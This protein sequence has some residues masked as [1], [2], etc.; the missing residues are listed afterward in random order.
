M[1]RIPNGAH[2]RWRTSSREV[3]TG[4]VVGYHSGYGIKRGAYYI[5]DGDD[6]QR[7]HPLQKTIDAQNPDKVVDYA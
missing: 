7:R 1:K 3:L 5:V 4:T 6:G 2:V